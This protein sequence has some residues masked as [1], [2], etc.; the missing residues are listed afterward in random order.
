MQ[1]ELMFWLAPLAKMAATAL[2]VVVATRIAE[3]AGPFIGAMVATLPLS[4]GPAY[5]FVALA[6]DSAFI[7]AS[8]VTSLAANAANVVFCLVH[9]ATAQSFGLAVSL[10][11]ALAAWVVF[12][13]AIHVADWTLLGAALLNLMVFAVCLP[14]AGR[15]RHAAMPSVRRHWLD[16]PLRA[17][18]VALLVVT[19]VGLSARLGPAVTGILALFPIVLTSVVLIFQPRIGGIA[20]AA[21]TANASIG[22]VGY[23]LALIALHLTAV[24]LGSPAGL[25]LAL[26]I[27]AGWNLTV[28]LVRRHV[29]AVASP[30]R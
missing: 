8:A 28:S 4:A 20:T 30:S 23:A 2:F 29:A 27:A 9:A 21:L 26:A 3:R 12:A 15:F 1:P 24:P 6:H 25:S 19:V 13:L 7:S 18:L 22:L 14:L 16:V 10:L 17:L 5:V 11:A